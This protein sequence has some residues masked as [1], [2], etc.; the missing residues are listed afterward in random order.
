M[1]ILIAETCDGFQVFVATQSNTERRSTELYAVVRTIT[2][3]I[4][5]YTGL[6]KFVVSVTDPMRNVSLMLFPRRTELVTL[7][8]TGSR[9]GST[10]SI[11]P[12]YNILEFYCAT[13]MYQ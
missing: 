11:I 1:K 6:N 12:K 4:Q 8:K 3:C 5:K 10:Y 2:L 13:E 7:V 9:A